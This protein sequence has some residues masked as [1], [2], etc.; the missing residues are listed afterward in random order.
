[1]RRTSTITQLKLLQVSFVL[2]YDLTGILSSSNLTIRRHRKNTA[3]FVAEPPEGIVI[4]CTFLKFFMIDIVCCAEYQ[5]IMDR[6]FISVGGNH[7]GVVSL[8]EFI[9]QFHSGL[10]RFLCRNFSRSEGLDYVIRKVFILPV[11]GTCE[12]KS[13]VIFRR[14]GRAGIRGYEP[15]IIRLFRVTD[16]VY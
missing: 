14:S 1:M 4:L 2:F 13:E 11:T 16:I 10:V 7:I 8:Q 9:C 5:M 6:S 15:H 12:G 3:E